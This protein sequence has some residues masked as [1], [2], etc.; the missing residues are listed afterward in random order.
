MVERDMGQLVEG[1]YRSNPVDPGRALDA[2]VSTYDNYTRNMTA[3]MGDKT[4]N[5]TLNVTASKGNEISHSSSTNFKSDSSANDWTLVTDTQKL[6][7]FR[8]TI[9]PHNSGG[10]FR[11]VADPATGPA[12][13]MRVDKPT[14]SQIRIRV[15]NGTDSESCIG[16]DP[17]VELD[18][19]G[20]TG[21]FPSTGTD[22]PQLPTIQ[23]SVSSP[24][25]IR[26]ENSQHAEGQYQLHVTG[27]VQDSE[28]PGS[29]A[30][31]PV[32]PAIDYRY[33]NAEFEYNRTI[34]IEPG[35]ASP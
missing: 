7:Q 11:V 1:V 16:N 19:L 33:Q 32:I 29:T 15:N 8:M 13:R 24:Y 25:D 21:T 23:N 4:V 6:R 22:C 35:E 30:P 28:I 2:N 17:D 18:L 12:W 14:S 26:F 31:A 20:G 10:A 9:E 3:S 34:L 27:D 5:T